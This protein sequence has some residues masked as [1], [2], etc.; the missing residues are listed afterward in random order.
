LNFKDSTNLAKNDHD[1]NNEIE[2]VINFEYMQSEM[3]NFQMDSK[4]KIDENFIENTLKTF[5]LYLPKE[6]ENTLMEEL[7]KMREK[8]MIEIKEII[9][10]LK[11]KGI[12]NFNWETIYDNF[13]KYDL[14]LLFRDIKAEI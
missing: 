14:I 9:G 5:E 12:F 10:E 1:L 3:R 7:K 11:F 6:I 8:L 4:L 13:A 2:W